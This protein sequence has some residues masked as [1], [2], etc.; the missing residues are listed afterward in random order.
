MS[1]GNDI[2]ERGGDRKKI[3]P[4]RSDVWRTTGG[5]E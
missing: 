1:K 5:K 3:M 4:G 2:R